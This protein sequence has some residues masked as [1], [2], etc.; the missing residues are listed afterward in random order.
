MLENKYNEVYENY[1]QKKWRDVV[2]ASDQA[3]PQCTNPELKSK[4]CYLRAVSVGQVYNEDSLINSMRRIIA[5]FPNTPVAELAQVYLSTIDPAKLNPIAAN[6]DKDSGN[7]GQST[8]NTTGQLPAVPEENKNPF[9]YNANEMHYVILLV[10]TADLPV[11]GVKQDLTTFNT[12]YFSLQKFNINS[13][14][15]NN[16]QQM[17]TVAKFTNAETAMDYYNIL[18]KNE[19]FAPNIAN[20]YITVYAISATNYS[21][22]YNKKDQREFY[23]K[24]FRESYLKTE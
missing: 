5:E 3:I 23:D 1:N 21:T 7:N 19:K 2:T 24:F 4:Y 16:T 17:V 6:N 22:Y 9:V 18:I 8:N 20:N 14:Y 10:T 13:F 12:T 11:L 15:I